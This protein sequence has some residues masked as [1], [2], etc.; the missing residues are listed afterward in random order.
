MSSSSSVRGKSALNRPAAAATAAA[1]QPTSSSSPD[2]ASEEDASL[3]LF[4]KPHTI[5]LL[6]ACITGLTVIAFYR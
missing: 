6:V 3:D 4:Y 5:S 1:V 2:P